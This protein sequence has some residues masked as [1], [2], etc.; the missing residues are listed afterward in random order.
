MSQLQD[1]SKLVRPRSKSPRSRSPRQY[2]ATIKRHSSTW[3]E[4]LLEAAMAEKNRKD[5]LLETWGRLV[6]TN[7]LYLNVALTE[8]EVLFGRRDDCDVYIDDGAVSNTHCRLWREEIKEDDDEAHAGQYRIWL[9]DLSTNGTFVDKKRVGKH[10]KIQIHSGTEIVLIPRGTDREKVSFI[11]YVPKLEK[12]EKAPEGKVTFVFTDVQSSTSLW[13]ACPKAMNESLRMHD[14]ILRRVLKRFNGYEVKT[15]GDAFMVT[16]FSPIDAIGWCVAV[17]EELLNA[18]WPAQLLKQRAARPERDPNDNDKFIFRGIR[19]RMGIHT[20]QPN[21]RRNPVTGRMDYFGPVVNRS[22]RVS[23]SAHGGQ[24]AITRE[25][26]AE[27]EEAKKQNDYDERMPHKLVITDVGE[28]QY[29]GIKDLVQVFQLST[30]RFQSRKFPELRTATKGHAGTLT[31]PLKIIDSDLTRTGS[32]SSD[33]A[34]PLE[35]TKRTKCSRPECDNVESDDA[36]FGVCARCKN[37]RYCGN[38]CQRKHWKLHKK[39]CRDA[40]HVHSGSP[41]KKISRTIMKSSAS[42]EKLDD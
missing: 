5:T 38:D 35:I 40:S 27:L 22:A 34:P 41:N 33:D 21:C 19:V 36:P 16:F 12:Q 18:N 10:N 15:E 28:H 20:G 9:E 25:V 4:Q 29:K 7:P 3:D 17:Q 6:S 32:L 42:K 23:D 2:Q 11:I 14:K 24:I 30:E 13:E 8:D 39:V 31:K 26:V 1:P 37:A